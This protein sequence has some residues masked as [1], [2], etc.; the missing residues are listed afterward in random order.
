MAFIDA[1]LNEFRRGA[2]PAVSSTKTLLRRQ[3]DHALQD[4]HATK[5]VVRDAERRR[6]LPSD[7]DSASPAYRTARDDCVARRASSG[8]RLR[9]WSRAHDRGG[10]G[11]DWG[12]P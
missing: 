3:S 6:V 8:R 4:L 5:R 9:D 10:Q 7:A 12:V 1:R 11:G 2:F